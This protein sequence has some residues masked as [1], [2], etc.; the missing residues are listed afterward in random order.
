MAV[1]TERFLAV[2]SQCFSPLEALVAC[3]SLGMC[4]ISKLQHDADRVNGNSQIK[5]RKLARS[6]TVLIY[7]AASKMA[8]EDC[9]QIVLRNLKRVSNLSRCG[10]M[11]AE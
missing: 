2:S 7:E 1:R 8:A 9:S 5:E 6:A 4:H 3:T 10:Y 11:D